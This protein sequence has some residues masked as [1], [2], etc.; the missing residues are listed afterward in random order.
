MSYRFLLLE[1]DPEIAAIVLKGLFAEG[2][3]GEWVAN[4]ERALDHIQSQKYDFMISDVLLMGISG[5]EVVRK[6][7]AIHPELPVIFLSALNADEERITGLSCGDEYLCKPFSV[8]ELLIRIRKIIQPQESTAVLTYGN[9]KLDRL[10]RKVI[11]GSNVIEMQEREFKLLDLFLSNPHRIVTREHIL[12]EICGYNYIPT[13][14]VL[15]VLICRLR[16][17]VTA[18]TGKVS[19]RTIR[20]VGYKVFLESV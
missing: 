11:C 12:R 9:L 14:N 19:I 8:T 10:K 15:D 17:K 16:D 20:G 6:V 3:E 18:G 1:D 4:G 2:Y 7:K 5:F 13:T